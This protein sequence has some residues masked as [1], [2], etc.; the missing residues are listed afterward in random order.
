MLHAWNLSPKD[1]TCVQKKLRERILLAWEGRQVE[2]VAGVDVGISAETACCAIVVL[3][4]PDL[5]PVASVT[6]DAPFVFPYI[7]GLLSFREGP[8]VLAAW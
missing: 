6:A 1:A 2:T 3:S 7:P 8:V 5:A 4:Y